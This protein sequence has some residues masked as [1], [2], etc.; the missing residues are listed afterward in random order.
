M[1]Y[2]IKE[3]TDPWMQ[4]KETLAGHGN[5]VA[6]AGSTARPELAQSGHD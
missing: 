1:I 5:V 3:K 6:R 4:V 2:T